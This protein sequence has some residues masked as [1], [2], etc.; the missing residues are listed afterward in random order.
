[1]RRF[2]V[3]HAHGHIARLAC[4]ALFTVLSAPTQH[5]S[6][7]RAGGET[8]A[9]SV[10]ATQ[11]AIPYARDFQGRWNFATATPWER[12]PG[13]SLEIDAKDVPAFEKKL[14]ELCSHCEDHPD[15]PDQVYNG[16]FFE[17]HS[18]P[19]RVRGKV[20]TSLIVDPPDGRLPPLAPGARE[21]MASIRALEGRERTAKDYSTVIRCIV[22]FN[23]GPPLTPGTYGN[24][25]QIIQNDD[26]VVM[27]TEHVHQARTFPVDGRAHTGIR[28][29]LGDSVGRWEG[30]TLVVD[31]INFLNDTGFTIPNLHGHGLGTRAHLIERFTRLE[32]DTLLYSF[33]IDDPDTWTRP[34]TMEFT[35]RRD[36]NEAILEYACHEGNYAMRNS[37]SENRAKE[38]KAAGQQK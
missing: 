22:G 7:T 26:Y 4:V 6:P 13:T 16:F 2:L 32:K 9:G 18:N 10:A 34:W 11:R 25:V 23:T 27:T 30:D 37:L 38:K 35:M 20:R 3:P 21:R 1:M 8:A 24:N 12:P 28:Q 33:M 5:A 14:K 15:D 19:M 17:M 29:F 36:N 31:S